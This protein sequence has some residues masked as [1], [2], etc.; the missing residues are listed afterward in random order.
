MEKQ[1]QW[2]DL[3]K[4]VL[5]PPSLIFLLL[6]QCYSQCGPLASFRASSLSIP[7][8]VYILIGISAMICIENNDRQKELSQPLHFT[9]ENSDAQTFK[10]VAEPKLEPK[11]TKIS[12]SNLIPFIALDSLMSQ[13]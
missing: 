2:E 11:S 10:L 12:N 5:L 1:N 7:K 3:P 9:N 13:Y 4:V 6:D 8:F